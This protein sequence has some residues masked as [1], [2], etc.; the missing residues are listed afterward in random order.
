MK[1]YFA[2]HH[3]LSHE[4]ST[5][6]HPAVCFFIRRIRSKYL[7]HYQIKPFRV[8][9]QQ[10]KADNALKHGMDFVQKSTAFGCQLKLKTVCNLATKS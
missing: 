2:S 3:I 7:C 10:D 9:Y 1:L 6:S 5:P 8:L 4:K